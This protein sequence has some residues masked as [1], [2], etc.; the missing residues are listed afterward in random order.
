MRMAGGG[1]PR[2]PSSGAA[3]PNSNVSDVGTAY[4]AKWMTADDVPQL[5]AKAWLRDSF[6]VHNI[7]RRKYA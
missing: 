6:I 4:L 2:R 5:I 7:S 3:K 1:A